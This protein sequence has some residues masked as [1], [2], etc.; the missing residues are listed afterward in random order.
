MPPSTNQPV[1]RLRASS[2]SS[3]GSA[4]EAGSN[5][6]VRKGA[7]P[8]SAS[9]SP[10]R[11][12]AAKP[13]TTKRHAP[14][15]RA[16]VHAEVKVA[17][18]AGI[19]AIVKAAGPVESLRAL[20]NHLGKLTSDDERAEAQSLWEAITKDWLEDGSMNAPSSAARPSGKA[21]TP[22]LRD[23]GSGS[24][25]NGSHAVA[26]SDAILADAASA[27]EIR[28]LRERL[29]AGHLLTALEMRTLEEQ[30][31]RVTPPIATAD[32]RL[33]SFDRIQTPVS[34]T[35]E[36][37]GILHVHIELNEGL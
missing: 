8:P 31:E 1:R 29:A 11:D 34:V 23:K 21:T 10:A 6:K 20:T 33:M 24:S 22:R 2:E 14:R 28:E 9:P 13:N 7:V 32:E 3:L 5:S 30:T 16:P 12:I 27:E 26:G 17:V 18:H 36:A 37:S 4:R 19:S 35:T 15:A 25:T